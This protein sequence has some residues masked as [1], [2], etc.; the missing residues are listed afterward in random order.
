MNEESAVV[1]IIGRHDHLKIFQ[2]KPNK[3][4]SVPNTPNPIHTSHRHYIST[5]VQRKDKLQPLLISSL[6]NPP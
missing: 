5:K 6:I 2:H 3:L 1:C 4:P